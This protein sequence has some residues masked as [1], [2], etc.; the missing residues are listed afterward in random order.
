MFRRT[1]VEQKWKSIQIDFVPT[2]WYLEAGLMMKMDGVTLG[3]E[4]SI[5][6]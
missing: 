2:L 3:L 1:C 4:I 6:E 5:S